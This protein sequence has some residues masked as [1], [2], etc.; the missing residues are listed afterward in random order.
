MPVANQGH[1]SFAKGIN[2][3]AS[4]DKLA[5]GECAL[6]TNVD[7]S[8]DV[9]ATVV[10]RG[11]IPNATVGTGNVDRIFRN[12]NNP[13]NIGLSPTYVSVKGDGVYRGVNSTWS[14]IYNGDPGEATFGNMM[15]Y[16]FISIDSTNGRLK[17][18]GT[19]VTD[20]IIEQPANAPTL[21]TINY[22]NTTIVSTMVVTD[23]GTSTYT[24]T[25]TGWTPVGGG[26]AVFQGTPNSTN[27]S[28]IGT[29]DV[30][31][32]GVDSLKIEFSDFS[33]VTRVSRDFSIGDTSFNNYLHA[34]LDLQDPVK[35]A[36]DLQ[37]TAADLLFRTNRVPSR[38]TG[39]G[40]TPISGDVYGDVLAPIGRGRNQDTSRLSQVSLSFNNWS[41]SR[42]K[43]EIV[44]QY[45]P[46]GGGSPWADIKAVRIN[47]EASGATRIRI[48]DW[49]LQGD[50]K[51]PLNDSTVGYS[52]Y[53]TYAVINTAGELLDQSP[54]SSG[55][56]NIHVTY[57]QPVISHVGTLT[58]SISGV[59]NRIL[60]RVGGY[61][62]EP[63][64]VATATHTSGTILFTDTVGDIDALT[65]GY[66][67]P[68]AV[69]SNYT[70]PATP[71]GAVEYKQR[72]FAYI[73]N[74]LIWSDI[75]RP[76]TFPR[77]NYA[78]VG[79]KG[80]EVQV[81]HPWGPSLLIV[82]RD[83]VYEMR[84]SIFEGSNQ[85]WI[86]ARSACTHGSKAPRTCVRTPY[87][88]VLMDYDGLTFYNPGQGVETDIPWLTARIGDMW[89]GTATT[90][91][92]YLKGNRVP[93]INLSY[94]RDSVAAYTDNKLYIGVPT[95]TSTAPNTMIVI[96]FKYE[97]VGLYDYGANFYSM[98]WDFL[99]NT[100]LAG[101]ANGVYQLEAGVTDAL[102]T[103]TGI[104]W[105]VRSKTWTSPADARLENIAIEY[106]GQA[107][108]VNAVYDSTS[109]VN[110]GTL[111]NTVRDWNINPLNGSLCNNIYFEV[112]GTSSNGNARLSN[113]M[114]DA[115]VEPQQVMYWRTEYDNNGHTGENLW[116]VHHASLDI[117]G[118]GTITAVS[119]IDGSA[120]MTNT[121]PGP[122]NG[123]TTFHRAF[124]LRT[125]GNVAYT[126]YTS[127]SS[128]L[129][130]KHFD[131]WY[132][133]RKEPPPINSYRSDMTSMDENICDALNVDINPN[134]TVTAVVYV[135]NAAV[136]TYSFTGTNQ[137]SYVAALP[138]ETYGRTIYVNYT[139]ANFK[140]YNTW[141]DLRPEPDRMTNFVINRESKDEEWVRNVNWDINPLSGTVL[142][143]IFVDGT[144]YSTKTCTG[145]LRQSFVD[146][147]PDETMGRTK[148][149]VYNAQGT[150]KFKHYNTWW[151]VT[152]E[153]DR[154]TLWHE[155]VPYSSE[156]Y[157][158]TWVAEINPLGTTVGTML[159]DGT[160]VWT[161]TFTGTRHQVFNVGVDIAAFTAQSTGTVLDIIYNAASGQRLK[162]YA[163]QCETEPKPFGKRTWQITYEKVGGASRL[164]HARS[165]S[166]D[167]ET[168]GTSTL[169]SV[170]YVDGRQYYTNTLTFSSGREWREWIP[171]PPD[172]R[173]YIF[174]QEIKGDV[175][176]RVWRSMI[177]CMRE[178][179]KGVARASVKGK[180][181]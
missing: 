113:I 78:Q 90:A 20:W 81:L 179:A 79:A 63:Y 159:L 117:V 57:G 156:N 180:P 40:S 123:R 44:G 145:S 122:T 155:R 71:M 35:D 174:H 9:G 52:Y 80:D 74:S 58:S 96:N 34:E 128:A 169:T 26:V 146:S 48:K 136:G 42:P 73:S 5:D 107:A 132:S 133:A 21:G 177:D 18:D 112:T 91:P 164:D 13:N 160:A 6:A 150:G 142:S 68:A 39:G 23:T 178:G 64:A 4:P 131:T 175:D 105:K 14:K 19:N 134:G 129:R 29:N 33:V 108:A 50:S 135:D 66:K 104:P 77:A 30:A 76:G 15:D 62:P 59:N 83:S 97:T 70:I 168:A 157:I 147:L 109:T 149:V 99:D 55:L 37:P 7:F 54:P 98:Y 110:L 27:L 38:G 119:F 10:R 88:V 69:Y 31:D 2:A 100:L 127:T 165:Y 101:A 60:Y 161:H 11:S 114:F 8:A 121:F 94:L 3:Q 116:D 102:G 43:Y 124:P 166:L 176:F 51:H 56:E 12:Y 152:P 162:H 111:T 65:I 46:T 72:L 141:W 153:P 36:V 75:A 120:V 170:W 118:T 172:G 167:I 24:G 17:D 25:F 173:G 95:G 158:K 32:F 89:R 144:A 140:H 163:T 47:V 82:N 130:I 93:A 138:N 53:V 87:G 92:A 143:T 115:I 154:V 1:L 148:W 84:G 171:L 126:T 181:A 151:D 41:V 85:D 137:Q 28:V 22:T 139:G 49:L 67:L 61:L 103:A 106:M 125:Y 86:L 16:T 45:N